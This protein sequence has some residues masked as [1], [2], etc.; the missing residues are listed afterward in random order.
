MARRSEQAQLVHS[1]LGKGY[2]V[3]DLAGLTGRSSR[4]I[5]QAR[6]SVEQVGKSGKMSS[7]KG[8]NLIPALKQLDERGKVSPAELPERRKTRTGQE[9]KV[10]KG[11]TT[12]ITAKGKERTITN[13]KK[14]PA[15]LKQSIRDAASKNQHVK[16]T[17]KAKKVKTKSDTKGHPG[18]V[19]G[20]TPFG[21]SARDLLDRI[22]NPRADDNWS[23]G[24]VN[25]ALIALAIE[26]N[27]S[28]VTSIS[29]IEEFTM[30]AE[31]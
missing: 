16:W 30:W 19:T 18:Y 6:D 11:V 17:I 26:Q 8:Q 21:W 23:A 15:T 10:R 28:A 20:H 31:L 27:S 12:T 25:G 9:A 2:S 1:L 14:G 7:G 29:G 5:T 22:D 24:D 13:V 4:Y 3:K